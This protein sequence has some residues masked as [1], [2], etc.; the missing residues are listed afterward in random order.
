MSDILKVSVPTSGY[1]NST[2]SN[3]ILTTDTNIQNIVDPSKV[4][5]PDAQGGNAEKQLLLNYE[6]NFGKFLSILKETPN[7]S[8]IFSQIF[9]QMG[10]EVSSGINSGFA[11]EFAK[12]MS[13]IN[14]SE[15]DLLAFI[16]NQANSSVK[17]SGNF[18]QRLMNVLYSTNSVDLQRELLN[19]LKIF[20]DVSSSS[21]TLKNI[22]S[23]LRNMEKY[24]L[25]DAADNLDNLSQK[26]NINNRD[27]GEDAKNTEILKKEIIPFLSSYIKRTNDLGK[28]RDMITMLTL[29]IA[30]YENGS[31]GK[32]FQSFSFL[33][34]FKDFSLEFSDISFEDLRNL[35]IQRNNNDFMDQFLSIMNRALRGENGFETKSIFQGIM[36]S[37]LINESVYMPLSHFMLPMDIAGKL[38]FSEIWIDPDDEKKDSKG[39]NARK[40]LIK[41]DIKDLGFFDLIIG[42][43]NGNI[44]LQLFYPTSLVSEE[45]SIKKDISSIIE[46][47]GFKMR[48]SSFS[49]MIKPKTITEV[50]PKIYERKNV[51]NVKI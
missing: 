20:N 45:K 12:F 48:S 18:F 11:A 8:E 29:N 3:P 16:K 40:L 15:E 39:G 42:E 27:I 33:K 32:L 10:T 35:I 43:E 2:R 9:F 34:D 50:F 6:S 44:D 4:V 31:F 30:K 24:M 37:I 19:F 21:S 22:N 51:V 14:M 7:I 41:F 26:L 13:M 23:I 25:S 47:N 46:K 38:M 5:R 17:F 28:V 36:S 49:K 1:E